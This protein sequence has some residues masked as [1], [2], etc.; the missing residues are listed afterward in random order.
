MQSSPSV[1]AH[2]CV[3]SM[4]DVLLMRACDRCA[5]KKKKSHTTGIVCYLAS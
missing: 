4:M 1:R 2:E 5:K 3:P